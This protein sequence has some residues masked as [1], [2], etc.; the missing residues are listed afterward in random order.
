MKL[1]K[2]FL[3]LR[4]LGFLGDHKLHGRFL[5][6]LF[7]TLLV[8]AQSTECA[9]RDLSGRLG[10]G[11]TNEF[12]NSTISREVPALSTKYGLSKDFHLQAILGFN[13]ESPAAYTLG[14]KAYKNI[15]FETNLN[16]YMAIGVAWLKAE[17]SG[18]ELLGVLGAEFFIPGI[19]SLGLLFEAGVSANN[20]TGD[21][22]LKTVGFSFIH[23]GMHFYF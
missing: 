7:L 17:K 21:F 11:F 12:S 9:A 13:T 1:F 5:T 8:F 18:F 15:F 16:F 3:G 20:V 23:A 10:F 4:E 19:D 14:A 22:V 2:P 6:G